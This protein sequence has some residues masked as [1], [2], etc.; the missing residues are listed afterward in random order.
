MEKFEEYRDIPK[1]AALRDVVD[2]LARALHTQLLREFQLQWLVSDPLAG[3]AAAAD[4]G[5][6]VKQQLRAEQEQARPS[7]QLPWLVPSH[8]STGLCRP[9]PP[10]VD[11]VPESENAAVRI[12]GS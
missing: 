7:A 3:R 4:A 1:V 6:D 11:L 5:F 9:R 2:L 8:A 10:D 12:V